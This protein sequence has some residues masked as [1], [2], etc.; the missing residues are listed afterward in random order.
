MSRR[1][2]SFISL[3][4]P[5]FL[6]FN[7]AEGENT[8]DDEDMSSDSESEDGYSDDEMEIEE[9]EDED[10]EDEDMEDDGVEDGSDV[11]MEVVGYH[12]DM[13]TYEEEESDDLSYESDADTDDEGTDLQVSD[14]PPHEPMLVPNS[15]IRT[16]VYLDDK[17]NVPVGPF[18]STYKAPL[19]RQSSLLGDAFN[20]SSYDIPPSAL[21]SNTQASSSHHVLASASTG[22]EMPADI[23]TLLLQPPEA[24]SP[25]GNEWYMGGASPSWS[26]SL[27]AAPG[28]DFEEFPQ[29]LSFDRDGDTMTLEELEEIVGRP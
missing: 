7:S 17:E 23:S 8:S 18:M 29:A 16:S 14:Q 25:A 22:N 5:L 15:P 20:T 3:S 28:F 24:Y 9:A 1:L 11:E 13:D 19:S 27:D 6:S 26:T 12:E 2:L 4:D 10:V 21:A